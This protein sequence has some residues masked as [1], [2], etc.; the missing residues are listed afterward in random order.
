MQRLH[1]KLARVFPKECFLQGTRIGEKGRVFS[2]RPDVGEAAIGLKLSPLKQR[3]PN[4]KGI[5]DGLFVCVTANCDH[6]VVTLV[7][8][9]GSD[10]PKAMSQIEDSCLSLCKVTNPVLAIHSNEVARAAMAMSR[11]GHGSGV[12]G[13]I[14]A[15]TGLA[16]SQ[17][18]RSILWN[19]YKLRIWIKTNKLRE[20]KCA[21]LAGKFTESN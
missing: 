20:I 17:Q 19:R 16:L 13:V 10:V 14:V 12:L 2:I 11:R 7:E 3:W 5:C 6:L 18:K 9:K 1:E 21:E 4:G 15:K 8:L